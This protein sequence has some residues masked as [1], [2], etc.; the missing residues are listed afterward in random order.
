MIDHGVLVIEE[1][2]ALTAPVTGTCAIPVVVGTAP[3]NM[4]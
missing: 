3:V 1:D 4:V 2:T